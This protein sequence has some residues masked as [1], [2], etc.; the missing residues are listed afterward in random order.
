MELNRKV[1]RIFAPT[2]ITAGI[3]GFVVPEKKSLMSGAKAYNVFHIVGGAAGLACMRSPRRAR[4]FN[5]A[6]GAVDLYQFA[7][8]LAGLPPKRSF[9][10]KRADDVLHIAVGTALLAVAARDR[11]S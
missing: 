5:A 4:A 1:L 7:A 6:F 2:L 10:W 11:R 9:R 8:S 3:A